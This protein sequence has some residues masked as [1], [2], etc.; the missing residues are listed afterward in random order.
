MSMISTH[1]PAQ[2]LSSDRLLR[3]IAIAT[4]NLLTVKDSHQ[5]VQSALAALGPATDVDRIYIFENHPHPETGEP[6]SSQRWEWVAEGVIPEIDNPELQNLLY[7]AILPRWYD[8]L[9]QEQPI[10]GL[11]KDFPDAERE[12]LQPQGILSI[13]VV[14]IFIRDAFWGF[15]GFDDCHQERTWSESMLAALMA[16][17]G[18]IGGAISQ[19]QSEA[20]L[21]QLNETL[22]YRV[23][24]R[25]AELQRAK[26]QAETASRAKSDFL[27][28][29]SHE[30]RTPLN[31][32]L[33]FTQV[34]LRDLNRPAAPLPQA[35]VATQ[36]DTL[37]I[38]YRS[39]NHLLGLIN[40]VLDMAKIEAGQ[41][42][43]N[44]APFDLVAM[45]NGLMEMLQIR[46]ATQEIPLIYQAASAIPQWVVGDERKLRQ[47]L[48][49]L[50]GNALKF[51][52]QGSVT[53]TVQA[54][55]ADVSTP[56][57]VSF[58]ISD[59]GPGIAPEELDTLFTPFVQTETGRNSQEG[60]GLGLPISR[61]FVQLM[62][63]DLTV[64][65]TV[66]VGSC[67][68][69][70]IA[71]PP[72]PEGTHTPSPS[73][74]PVIGLAPGQPTYRIL[75]VD[76]HWENRQVLIQ[77]LHPLGF[78]LYEAENGQQAIDQWR[79]HQ[80]H[81]IW[82]DIRM[83][84][85]NGYEATR[86][87]K[88]QPGGDTT[89]IIALTASIFEDERAKILNAGCSDF[90]RKPI[91]EPVLLDK[92]AQHL[93]V[94]YLYAD[95]LPESS[96]PASEAANGL[97]GLER[98]PRDWLTQLHCAARGAEEDRI[99][100]LLG[101]LTEQDADLAAALTTL[102]DD[103]RFDIIVNLTGSLRDQPTGCQVIGFQNNSPPP[104]ILVADD[105]L[106][107]RQLL[108]SLLEPIGFII[109]EAQT[110][111]EAVDLCQSFHPHLVLMDVRMPVMNGLEATRRIK[112]L[113]PPEGSPVPFVIAL[114]ASILESERPTVYA[115][116]CDVL[117]Q[118]PFSER[119]LLNTLAKLLNLTYCYQRM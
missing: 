21:K 48:I 44:E 18:S 114:T 95:A 31:A 94:S 24:T 59:T 7:P 10:L 45:L 68:K 77:F 111:Q 36:R 33:G 104:R 65:T 17:A 56:H 74:C 109:T 119:E 71:L 57:W 90:V 66:N 69:F 46:A 80:P 85:M 49:N 117:M 25:T 112:R 84:V 73:P 12:L 75:V 30:L 99:W 92:L 60:T 39:G 110:G 91:A 62:G 115:A 29:M 86:Y 50:L 1:A 107:N 61:K 22:E 54:S 23:V 11:I 6:A 9:S 87:I 63:G 35:V 118:K 64:E 26:E 34:M 40:D 113:N 67:F 78:E 72:A 93:G 28:N 79:R 81:L 20:N 32:I 19:R 105:R 70:A 13:L 102:V 37:N 96:A 55:Q 106:E 88:S 82:M 97:A 43:L 16:I 2:V 98:Q 52:Q 51:T 108:R 15:A 103:F 8:T 101:H 27:A 4:N 53:L 83:P 5:A 47:V 89:V 116:G 42:T 58:A 3:G 14:P 41:L 100:S 38:I 76:D